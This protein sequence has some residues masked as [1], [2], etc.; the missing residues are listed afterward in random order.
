MA[1]LL[2][3]P[4]GR[5]P[6]HALACPNTNHAAAAAASTLIAARVEW[7]HARWANPRPVGLGALQLRYVVNSN[8]MQERVREPFCSGPPTLRPGCGDTLG[9][10][11]VTTR[12]P[13]HYAANRAASP[14][15]PPPALHPGSRHWAP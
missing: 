10:C 2:D 1:G 6:S 4:P 9:E 5:L 14:E 15:V 11:A 8:T 7:M 3:C 13:S 12:Q